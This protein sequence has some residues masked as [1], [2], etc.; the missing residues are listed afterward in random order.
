MACI[1]QCI[2]VDIENDRATEQMGVT[3]MELPDPTMDEAR[4]EQIVLG[5][6][7]L[8]KVG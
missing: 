7:K 6:K 5:R 4:A 2:L 1:M 8:E 3:R